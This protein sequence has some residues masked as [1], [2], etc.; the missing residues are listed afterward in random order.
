MARPASLPPLVIDADEPSNPGV[1][2]PIAPTS[3]AAT[4]ISGVPYRESYGN[5]GDPGVRVTMREAL[6]TPDARTVREHRSVPG[7]RV[8]VRILDLDPDG[9]TGPPAWAARDWIH[10]Q[11]WRGIPVVAGPRSRDVGVVEGVRWA[12]DGSCVYAD[13]WI[14]NHTP[15]RAFDRNPVVIPRALA[16]IMQCTRGHVPFMAKHIEIPWPEYAAPGPLYAGR[17]T[18]VEFTPERLA[19]VVRCVRSF[20]FIPEL[21][22][23][24]T[25][26][27]PGYGT[28]TGAKG[29][30]EPKGDGQ[31]TLAHRD[32]VRIV[33]LDGEAALKTMVDTA[34]R[35]R[36]EFIGTSENGA[37]L[38]LQVCEFF[39]VAVFDRMPTLRFASMRVT[40]DWITLNHPNGKHVVFGH[41]WVALLGRG[42]V[43]VDMR[44]DNELAVAWCD[45]GFRIVPN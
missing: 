33:S 39:L 36:G 12:D 21:A 6:A 17:V 8:T 15:F 4:E 20:G 11:D 5:L 35:R 2:I 44:V 30:C 27:A 37:D 13:L 43:G 24:C 28:D 22:C 3:A 10:E 23:S 25:P 1:A 42:S 45:D 34:R 14:A 18:R 38:T 29:V 41:A 7:A 40:S 19:A 31:I 9:K 32:V 26:C 16:H